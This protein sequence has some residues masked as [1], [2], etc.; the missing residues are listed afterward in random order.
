[1]LCG[2][3]TGLD[4]IAAPH[5][6]DQIWPVSANVDLYVLARILTFEDSSNQIAAQLPV[7]NA[8]KVPKADIPR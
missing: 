4:Y 6:C 7:V 3:A 5:L 1:M 8:N 2:G